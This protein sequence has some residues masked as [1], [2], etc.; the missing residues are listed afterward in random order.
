MS[1]LAL[2][3]ALLY[4]LG[5]LAALEH[6][7][8]VAHVTCPEHGEALHLNEAGERGPLA[9]PERTAG[10]REASDRPTA[11]PEHEHCPVL[12]HLQPREAFLT[13]QPAAGAPST[14]VVAKVPVGADVPH[15]LA[16][17]TRAPKHSPPRRAC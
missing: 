16:P 8:G 2:T 12:S 17:G 14:A 3:L 10:V 1:R 11:Q 5:Q 7:A 15:D 13:S 4:G 6:L 9:A